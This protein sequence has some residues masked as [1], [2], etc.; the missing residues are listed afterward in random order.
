MA[1][2]QN[3]NTT[4]PA[5]SGPP[6]GSSFMSNPPPSAF[7]FNVN[8]PQQFDPRTANLNDLFKMMGESLNQFNPFNNNHR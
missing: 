5:Y 8:N 4:L 7:N 3:Q 1:P 2:G 6:P